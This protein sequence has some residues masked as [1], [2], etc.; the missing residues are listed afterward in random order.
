VAI[1]FV[2]LALFGCSSPELDLIPADGTILAFGDSLTV[3]VGV[4]KKN[5]YPVVLEELTG[6]KVISSGVSGETTDQGLIRLRLELDEI[7][8]DLLILIEGGNDILRNKNKNET[9][10]NLA[11]MIELAQEKGIQVVLIGVPEKK[12]FSSSA[13]FYQELSDRY[14]LVFDDDL[15][16]DLE[17]SPSDK[18][19]YI[20]FNKKGYN[21]MA[22]GVYEVLEENGAL[23]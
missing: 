15:I 10:A 8:P 20:H 3:G 17:R 5:S 1:I 7:H 18:S 23:K 9:K 4:A 19:D 13:P 11:A 22:V 21:K 2:A 6:L 14:N 16:S 12:L